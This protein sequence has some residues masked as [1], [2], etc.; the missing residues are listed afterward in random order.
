LKREGVEVAV[1]EGVLVAPDRVLGAGDLF[2]KR[3]ALFRECCPVGSSLAAACSIA[4]R[5]RLPSR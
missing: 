2:G 5:M 1:L 4:L 3:H